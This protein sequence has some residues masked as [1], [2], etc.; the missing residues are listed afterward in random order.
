MSVR[1]L[2]QALFCSILR[3]LDTIFVHTFCILK[4][5]T[6]GQIELD[7]QLF[8]YFYPFLVWKDGRSINFLHK[9]IEQTKA[10]VYLHGMREA[11]YSK[12]NV[13]PHATIGLSCLVQTYFYESRSRY[14]IT[15][16]NNKIWETFFCILVYKM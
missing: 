12:E 14:F 4:F 1:V 13:L 3:I 9:A 16:Y 8:H 6:D 7:Y 15:S 10:M 5:T 11:L 2:L